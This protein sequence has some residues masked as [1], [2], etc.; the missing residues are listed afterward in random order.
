MPVQ[1]CLQF[2]PCGHDADEIK[3]LLPC[4]F[5]AVGLVIMN[6]YVISSHQW[7]FIPFRINQDSLSD[8]HFD[9]MW[10]SVV[11]MRARSPR[12]YFKK[13]QNNLCGTVGRADD[14]L[15]G[16]LVIA[17]C[18]WRRGCFTKENLASSRSSD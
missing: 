1:T 9:Q 11:M 10:K 7:M 16:D 17:L 8:F 3:G 2:T 18:D 12:G 6:V 5:K 4:V 13:A 14:D 15:F